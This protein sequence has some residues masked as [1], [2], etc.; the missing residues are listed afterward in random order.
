MD[1]WPGNEPLILGPT[2]DCPAN[3]VP[4]TPNRLTKKGRNKIRSWD[5]KIIFG[6]VNFTN[7]KKPNKGIPLHCNC[8]CWILEMQKAPWHWATISKQNKKCW[9]ICT[10]IHYCIVFYD[11]L[12]CW[13]ITQHTVTSW[14]F[15]FPTSKWQMLHLWCQLLMSEVNWFICL[16][17]SDNP[18]GPSVEVGEGRCKSC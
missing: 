16:Q 1:M 13:T 3:G 6:W 11:I 8:K 18:P 17:L 15:F 9:A 5:S 14:V 2:D 12:L 7:C 4:V 10:H